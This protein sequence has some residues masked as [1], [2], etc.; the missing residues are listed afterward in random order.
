MESAEE[1]VLRT[2]GAEVARWAA[3]AQGGVGGERDAVLDLRSSHGFEDT[4]CEQKA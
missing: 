4:S 3:D 1:V 2:D